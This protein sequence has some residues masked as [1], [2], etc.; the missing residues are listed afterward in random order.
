MADP[1][2][3]RRDWARR[4]AHEYDGWP[5]W[6]APDAASGARS[7]KPATDADPGGAAQGVRTPSGWSWGIPSDE[8]GDVDAQLT[9]AQHSGETARALRAERAY[10]GLDRTGD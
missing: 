4:V 1:E 10:W 3:L 7:G 9:L 5:D 2:A 6:A 8:L